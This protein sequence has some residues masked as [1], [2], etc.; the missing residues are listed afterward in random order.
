M[1]YTTK[2]WNEVLSIVSGK[3]Q[4]TVANPNGQYPIYGSGGVMGY[5]DDYPRQL[6]GKAEVLIR[7]HRAGILGRICMDQCMVDV[8]DIPGVKIGDEAVLL[9]RQG[10]DCITAQELAESCGTIHYEIVTGAGRRAPR[11][12]TND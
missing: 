5:A 8:T 7:G 12:Y 9:G 2:R 1:S 11:V 6:S 10:D 4:K 3:N